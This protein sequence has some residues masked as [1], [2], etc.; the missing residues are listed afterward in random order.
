[1]LS[2]PPVGM[3][4]PLGDWP[5]IDPRPDRIEAAISDLQR[6]AGSWNDAATATTAC[7]DALARSASVGRSTDEERE[8]LGQYAT[9]CIGM[10]GVL[11]AVAAALDAYI[12]SFDAYQE[13][14][15]RARSVADAS[16]AEITAQDRS[17]PGPRSASFP[18]TP[19]RQ[20]ARSIAEDA[21]A[22]FTSAGLTAAVTVGDQTKGL[23]SGWTDGANSCSWTTAFQRVVNDGLDIRSLPGGISTM[24]AG[25]E[26][27]GR[28]NSVARTDE[29]L[30][31]LSARAI[32]AASGLAIKEGRHEDA[33]A[34][35]RVAAKAAAKIGVSKDTFGPVAIFGGMAYTVVADGVSVVTADGEKG[36]HAAATRTASGL[37]AASYVGLGTRLAEGA[38]TDAIDAPLPVLLAAT[39]AYQLGDL[40]Y[41]D[42]RHLVA[43]AE[44]IFG[45]P[46]A[47]NL[48]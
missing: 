21:L 22:D 30:H 38:L 34:V 27:V 31:V 46:V 19:L 16:I 23:K 29:A 43:D 14:M 1:V 28:A 20:Q 11:L 32:S 44:N 10:C 42:R 9:A 24:L 17:H 33:S 35:A 18:N 39:T 4:D 6:R 41:D 40:V 15:R 7:A 3:L 25:V 47:E 37:N 36:L 5:R 12:A 2:G 13:Q 26:L 45:H 8:A 48:P